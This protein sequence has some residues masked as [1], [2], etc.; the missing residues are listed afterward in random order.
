MDFDYSS[1]ARSWLFDLSTLR[2]CRQK[3]VTEAPKTTTG[4]GSVARVRQFASGFHR[5]HIAM[6]EN[7]DPPN[8]S[9]L[10]ISTQ[11]N[12]LSVKE[13]ELMVRFHAHQISQLVGPTAVLAGLVRSSTILATA[14]MIFRRFY[15]SNSLLDFPPQKMAVAAAFLATKVEENRIEVSIMVKI[16]PSPR[17]NLASNIFVYVDVHTSGTFRRFPLNK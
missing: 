8:V 13:Q 15:M 16:F 6:E 14:I 3:A 9:S 2:Q 4:R 12:S 10:D 1:Q 5:R 11:R 7:L 17:F